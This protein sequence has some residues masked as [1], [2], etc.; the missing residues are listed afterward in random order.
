MSKFTVDL[1]EICD[2]AARD[3]GAFVVG[4]NEARRHREMRQEAQFVS[5]VYH[6]LL[7]RNYES[8]TLF[9]EYLYPQIEIEGEQHK[10]KPD[11][12]F[13]SEQGDEVVEFR[14]FWDGDLEESGSSIKSTPQRIVQEYWEKLQLYTKLP[15]RISSLTLVVAYL[16]PGVTVGG[17]KKSQ[18]DFNFGEFRHSIE[19]HCRSDKGE[20]STRK[21]PIEVIAC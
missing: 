12:I 19:L 6:R 1:K 11:L 13:E 16:G 17:N 3:F 10:L 8:R 15:N 7:L 20:R 21:I 18:W 2:N 4:K 9:M 5:E 14:A